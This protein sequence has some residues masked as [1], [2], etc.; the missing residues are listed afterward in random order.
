MKLYSL[1]IAIVLL[2]ISS[3]WAD[4]ALPPVVAMS[5]VADWRIAAIGRDK[6]PVGKDAV[7][8]VTGGAFVSATVDA[9]DQAA[10]SVA[11]IDAAEF[12]V[13]NLAHRD[14]VGDLTALPK[15][16]TPLVSAS[17]AA[18]GASWKSHAIVERGGKKYAVI[19]IASKSDVTPIG[20]LQYVEPAEAIKKALADAG[21]VDGVIVLADLPLSDAAALKAANP[22]IDAVLVSASGGGAPVVADQPRIARAVPGGAALSVLPVGA[23][24]HGVPIDPPTEP[25]EP[26][27]SIA[28]KF[29]I[30][31]TSPA[32]TKASPA[33]PQA[34]PTAFELNRLIPI[35]KVAANRAVEMTVFAGGVFDS[36]GGRTAPEGKRFLVLYLHFKNILKPQTVRDQLVPVTYQIA[37][38]SDHLYLV[39]DEQAVLPSQKFD[40]AAGML[41]MDKQ[42]SLERAGYTHKGRVAY[43][44]PADAMPREL[45]LRLYDF[46]HG[47]V[48]LPVLGRKADDPRVVAKPSKSDRNEILELGVYGVEKLPKLGRQVVSPGMQVVVVDVRAISK[49]TYPADAT[50]FSPSARPGQK[51][52]VGTVSDWTESRK[53]LQLVVDGE[54]G[55]TPLPSDA[56]PDAPR[57]LPD[58]MTG[59]KVAFL[60]PAELKSLELRCDFPNAKMPDGKVVRPRGFTLPLEGNRPPLASISRP[61]AKTEDS[62]FFVYVMNQTLPAT[63]AEQAPPAG[64]KWIVLD[65]VVATKSRQGEFFQTKEQLKIVNAAG[66]QSPPDAVSYQGVYQPA[67]LVWI[68]QGE[69]RAFQVVYPWPAEELA[70]RLAYN[71]VDKAEVLNLMRLAPG[72]ADAPKVEVPAKVDQPPKADE[73][74][75]VVEPAKPQAAELPIDVN[76]Q[77]FP[78]RVPVKPNLQ[79]KGIAGVGVKPEQVNAAIDKGAEFLWQS[80]QKDTAKHSPLGTRRDH[81]IMAL[82]LIHC[83]LHKKNAQFDAALRKWLA[84]YKPNETAGTYEVGIMAMLIEAYG[85][86]TFFPQLRASTKWLIETQGSDGSW[87]YGRR[88]DNKYFAAD[89]LDTR[90]LKVEGGRPVEAIEHIARESE[91]KVEL[92][93]D[94]SATQYAILGLNSAERS[95]IKIPADVWARALSVHKERQTKEDG[96]WGYY[97]PGSP[98]GSM[99]AAGVCGVALTRYAL[100]QPSNDG[101][102]ERGLGWLNA[103]FSVHEHP[104]SD[105]WLYYYLYSLERVGRILD[106]EFIGE[107]EWYPQGAKFLIGKQLPQGSWSDHRRTSE[108]DIHTSFA[109]L[110]LTRAT[111]SLIA[112]KREGPGTLRTAVLIPPGKKLYIILDASGSMLEEMNGK[113]KFEIARAAL[114]QLIKEL[115]DNAEV[116]LRA[117]G[118]RKRAI[119]EGASEDTKLLVPVGKLERQ[120]LLDIMA[121]IRARGKTPMALSLEEAKGELPQGT[122]DAPVTVLLLTDGGEDSQP[123][124]DPVAAAAAFAK[125][126]HTKVRIVGFDINR[127]DWSQQLQAMATASGGQYLPAAQ[128]DTLLRE[129]RS[130]VYETPDQ[131]A[132]FDDAGKQVGGGKFGES[133]QLPAGKYRIR[134]TY[135]GRSF[136]EQLHV[137]AG[138]TTAVTFQAVNVGKQPGVPAAPPEK[139]AE[140][141]K[142]AE[143]PAAP[144]KAK[145]CT[146][147]GAKLEGAG[148]FCTSCGAKISP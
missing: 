128:G 119:E 21:Q 87:G 15:A 53:Y 138:V 95:G 89:A 123:R 8:T 51:T 97:A 54:R 13:V 25:A 85:D 103:H 73:P 86:P 106:T 19:G 44:V 46:A 110:F 10:R 132:L 45:V 65:V 26:Y 143:T 91:Y 77:K 36:F 23:Q 60:A 41:E 148:K 61:M 127:D 98:Y 52:Q 42:L 38:P 32:V 146:S 58:V 136:E 147:C 63:F 122:E 125:L 47:H 101:L 28:G 5:D 104:K 79:P 75:K 17:F 115:P 69:R 22:A 131:F 43:E 124:K 96:G 74:A 80:I 144:A 68:P 92:Q 140:V 37:K 4:R 94:M 31:A 35:G 40:Q 9:K 130:A 114:T 105:E 33:K 50:A 133:V 139:P 71:G 49:F 112:E 6:L 66:Q 113:P 129:L 121:G 117:Y 116:G 109:L 3:A 59:G 83:D 48:V 84:K 55:Y 2:M 102:V 142:P 64:T 90:V 34:T 62:V 72:G 70:P 134:A 12:D 108:E 135:A 120:K 39:A 137:N 16:K 111:P 88:I 126:P 11:L 18:A 29:G 20:N 82:A 99:T 76:G 56:W 93:G 78:A 107:H 118:Y 57:F 1:S 14:L 27:K 24:A 7:L 145:F 67:E 81:T 30:G 141:A 100:Q